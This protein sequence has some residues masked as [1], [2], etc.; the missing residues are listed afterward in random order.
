M[1]QYHE[2]KGVNK[3]SKISKLD[4]TIQEKTKVIFRKFPNGEVIAL[5]PELPGSND[6]TTCLN[7]MHNGQHGSGK[8]TL[9]GTTRAY[10]HDWLKAELESIGYNLTVV[11]RISYQMDQKRIAALR[12]V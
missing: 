5:F 9:E 3:M 6:L 8:A 2:Y 7:Y 12:A 11:T 1:K 4:A 10:A